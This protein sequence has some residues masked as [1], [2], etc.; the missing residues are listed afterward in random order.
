MGVQLFPVANGD[1]EGLQAFDFLGTGGFQRSAGVIDAFE[2]FGLAGSIGKHFL[3]GIEDFLVQGGL[4]EKLNKDTILFVIAPSEKFLMFT[5]AI[6]KFF[7]TTFDHSA[8]L[9]QRLLAPFHAGLSQI[10]QKCEGIFH[11]PASFLSPATASW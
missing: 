8:G 4:G 1:L 11:C 10:E 6:P 2:K 9:S 7:I 5:N 3:A